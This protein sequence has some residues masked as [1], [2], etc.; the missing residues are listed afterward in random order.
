ME[1]FAIEIK[2]DTK[3]KKKTDIDMKTTQISACMSANR[4]QNENR[5][6]GRI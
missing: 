5:Q 2:A 6:A 4:Q 3:I 1:P